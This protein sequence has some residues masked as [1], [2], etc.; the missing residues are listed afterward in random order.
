MANSILEKVTTKNLKKTASVINNEAMNISEDVVD[1]ALAAGNE[2]TKVIEKA[3]KHGTFL[4]GK[5]QEMVLDVLEGVKDQYTTGTKRTS[6]LIGFKPFAKRVRK[7]A[8]EVRKNAF[9]KATQTID[10]V[11]D[12]ELEKEI[13]KGKKTAKKLRKK[14]SVKVKQTIDEVLD[15]VENAPKAK[16]ASKKASAKKVTKKATAKKAVAKK[17]TKKVVAKKPVAKKVVR[18]ATKVVTVIADDLKKVNGIGP[19]MEIILNAKGIKTYKQLA[20]TKITVLREILTEAGPRYRMLDPKTWAKQSA[21][22][23]KK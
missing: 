4:F 18:K 21:T 11:L 13:K 19:K 23:A 22:L 10:E 6:K 16:K 3:V 20:A 9:N 1:G 12:I 15:I 2:W 17:A 14:A 7:A 5:Q 8:T